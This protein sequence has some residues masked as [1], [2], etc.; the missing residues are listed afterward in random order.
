MQPQIIRP[1][2]TIGIMGG[3]QLGRMLV[4]AAARMG[5]RTHIFTPEAASPASQIATHTTLA[6]YDD[7]VAL[8]QF[9]KSVDV[10][11]FEFENV[12]A[13]A[14]APLATLVPVHPKVDILHICRH[15]IREKE[16]IA[17]HGIATAPFRAVHSAVEL[18][19]AIARIGVPCVLKTCELGYDGKGQVKIESGSDAGT[20]WQSLRCA[21]AVLEGW[22]PFER[23]LSVIVAR[24]VAGEMA[25]YEPMH[26][27]HS[28]HILAK[29]MVPAQVPD[30]VAEQAQAIAATLAQA[31]GLVGILAVEL[32]LMKDGTLLVNELAPRAHNSGHW[33]IEAA[34]TS[35]FE[36]QIRAICG[37]RLGATTT[38]CPSVMLNLIGE[39]VHNL[40]AYLNDPHAHLHLYGKAEARKGRKMGHVT[41]TNP[42]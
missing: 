30:I 12:P 4:L 33:T 42:A 41:F 39:D 22:V 23:E 5:Y 19:E 3:G 34:A 7:R 10:M 14:I 27:H 13:A 31:L 1:G 40:D 38:L 21:E 35:Q 9:A 2:A 32:F 18:K 29:T 11:T 16:F 28:H 15:R 36:Q 37:H 24:S 6:A 17:S 26:N 25:C 8:E 20:I